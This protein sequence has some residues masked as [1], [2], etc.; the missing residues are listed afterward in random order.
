MDAG[1]TRTP[2]CNAFGRDETQE[3]NFLQSEKK[4]PVFRGPCVCETQVGRSPQKK[5]RGE[6]V[7]RTFPKHVF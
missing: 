5:T 2:G 6:I 4:V 1:G 3:Q 7:D